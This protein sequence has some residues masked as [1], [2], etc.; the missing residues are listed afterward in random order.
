MREQF[1][2]PTDSKY[3]YFADCSYRVAGEVAEALENVDPKTTEYLV[4]L[5]R[6]FSFP[7]AS[8]R[9]YLTEKGLKQ[10]AQYAKYM[11]PP[12]GPLSIQEV[13]DSDA[14][15]AK[16]DVDYTAPVPPQGLRILKQEYEEALEAIEEAD[17][18]YQETDMQERRA[19]EYAKAYIG[20]LESRLTEIKKTADRW[21]TST[22][23]I[24]RGRAGEIIDDIIEGRQ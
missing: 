9:L 21:Q 17:L 22:L 14:P 1:D 19:L 13:S 23:V 18:N 7:G 12:S 6:G 8:R 16:T 10:I 24:Q 15:V 3:V 4:E 11:L 2:A 20:E 5:Q